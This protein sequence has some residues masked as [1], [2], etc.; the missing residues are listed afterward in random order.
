MVVGSSA[1]VE[2]VVA[3]HET[4]KRRGRKGKREKGIA[5]FRCAREEERDRQ[6]RREK[7]KSIARGTER[8]RERER[9]KLEKQPRQAD[10]FSH[11]RGC[12]VTPVS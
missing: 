4:V 9:E 12:S 6:I 5:G 10:L 8:E 7:E 3:V 2:M 1:I 11:P